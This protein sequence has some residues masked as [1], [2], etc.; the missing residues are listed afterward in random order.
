[1]KP[2][3]RSAPAGRD[4]VVPNDRLFHLGEDLEQRQALGGDPLV[5][6]RPATHRDLH[7][8]PGGHPDPGGVGVGCRR[9]IGVHLDREHPTDG[10][11]VHG[12]LVDDQR[13]SGG[14][15]LLTQPGKVL[16]VHEFLDTNDGAVGELE[17]AGHGRVAWSRSQHRHRHQP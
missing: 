15:E 11:G 9:P 13:R 8:F 5:R 3:A 2:N 16:R 12:D 14:G 6:P 7:P 10:A 1:L 17:A 4:R